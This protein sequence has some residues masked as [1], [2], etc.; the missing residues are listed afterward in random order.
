MSYNYSSIASFGSNKSPSNDPLTYCLTES[1]DN[2]FQHGSSGASLYGPWSE[3]CQI[4]MAERSA[5]DWDMFSE[6]YYKAHQVNEW[7]QWPNTSQSCTSTNDWCKGLTV[8]DYML[9]NTA[10]R[11]YCRRPN[12]RLVAEPFDPNVAD[13]PWITYYESCECST[14]E[15]NCPIICDQ[16]DPGKLNDDVVMNHLLD[17]PWVGFNVLAN[18]ANNGA[19]Q[20]KD[21]SG[22]RFG[23]WADKYF[24]HHRKPPLGGL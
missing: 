4:Y 18:I 6:Y 10:E 1:L 3:H 21:F 11:K 19:R 8:G 23:Q 2:A 12:C 24:Q 15:Q 17:N 9:K 7:G 22:T 14:G 20:G 16:V 13:S 5:K